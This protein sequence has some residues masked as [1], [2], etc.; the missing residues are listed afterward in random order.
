MSRRLSW[1]QAEALWGHE[2]KSG[3][4]C[5]VIFVLLGEIPDT[6]F[7]S[8]KYKKQQA[9]GQIPGL[10]NASVCFCPWYHGLFCE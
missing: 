8:Y 3:T 4:C 5:F 2:S 10:S 1:G 6:A 9:L 7:S